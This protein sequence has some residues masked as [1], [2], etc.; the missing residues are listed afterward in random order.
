MKPTWAESHVLASVGFRPEDAD[1][2]LIELARIALERCYYIDQAA[3][4][5]AS[6]L[7]YWPA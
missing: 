1:D 2:E 4:Y 5:V 3:R 6:V 7:R